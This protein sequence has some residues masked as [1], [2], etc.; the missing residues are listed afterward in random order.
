MTSILKFTP[1]C[2]ALAEQPLCYLLEIDELRILLDCGWNDSFDLN[3]LKP[4]AKI[5]PK[6]IEFIQILVSLVKQFRSIFSK[7]IFSHLSVNYVLISHPD[8]DHL[9][10]LPY[11]VSKLVDNS[12]LRFDF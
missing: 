3:M 4:L 7:L 9:G 8:M 12:F 11:A 10:A 5:A 6:G 1:I 2:G